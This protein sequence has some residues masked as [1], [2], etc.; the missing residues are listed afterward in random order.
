[1]GIISQCVL[2]CVFVDDAKSD[3]YCR[4]I[5]F[6]FHVQFNGACSFVCPARKWAIHPTVSGCKAFNV[7]HCLHYNSQTHTHT[8]KTCM[9]THTTTHTHTNMHTHTSHILCLSLYL[10]LL[11]SF[12]HTHTHTHTHIIYFRFYLYFPESVV[13]SQIVTL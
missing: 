8:H 7:E 11:L 2:N 13:A 5:N 3:S 12:T 9:H 10:D 1:M 6:S 4:I